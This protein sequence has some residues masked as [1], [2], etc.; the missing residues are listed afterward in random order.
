MLALKGLCRILAL[1]WGM[2][3]G[4]AVAA[5]QTQAQPRLTVLMDGADANYSLAGVRLGM[6]PEE[7]VWALQSRYPQEMPSV[8]ANYRVTVPDYC[9][10]YQITIYP[11][12][13]RFRTRPFPVP[14]EDVVPGTV[15]EDRGYMKI[16][17]YYQVDE[18]RPNSYVSRLSRS[19]GTYVVTVFFSERVDVTLSRPL[20]TARA[21]RVEVRFM[22]PEPDPADTLRFYQE[23]ERKFGPP[24]LTEVS[25]AKTSAHKAPSRKSVPQKVGKTGDALW[26][27][28]KEATEPPICSGTPYLRMSADARRFQLIDQTDYDARIQAYLDWQ[29]GETKRPSF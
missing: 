18:F 7:A 12:N 21:S 29:A 11:G 1:G 4:A 24:T 6:T 17:T 25:L 15:I 9:E 26:C 8:T 13:Q 28:N 16:E 23:A 3:C 10:R 19:N 5:S 27:L 22:N 2:C 14:C 20:V